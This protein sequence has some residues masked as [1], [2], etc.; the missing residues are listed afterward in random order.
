MTKKVCR[1]V[2]SRLKSRWREHCHG[3]P[4]ESGCALSIG[5]AATFTSEPVVPYLGAKL[6]EKGFL[7]TIAAA[8]YNQILQVCIDHKSAFTT[9]DPQCICLLWRMEDLVAEELKQWLGGDRDAMDSVHEKLR[10]LARAMATLRTRFSGT[11][12]ITMPPFPCPVETSISDLDMLVTTGAFFRQVIHEW[13]ELLADIEGVRVLDLDGLQ[14]DVGIENSLDWRKWYLYRQ[15]YTESFNCRLAD[16]LA[17]ILCAT[18]RS[19]RKCISVDCD[20]TLWGGIIGEDGLGGVLLGHEFPGSAYADFQRLLLHWKNSGILLAVIS[21]N[22]EDDVRQVFRE[23]DGM[24]LRE[25][26]IA[27]W[28]VNWENKPDNLKDVAEELKIGVDSFVFVDDN[29][30]EIAQ[31]TDALPEVQSVQIPDD[32]ALIVDYLKKQHFF[33]RCDVSDEDR[34]RTEMLAAERKRRPLQQ[35]LSR[36]EFIISLR[37][38]IELFVPSEQQIGRVTQLI[39]KTNQFNLTTIRRTEDEVRALL[40][41]P[42]YRMFAAR[43]RDRFG[44]YGLTGLVIFKLDCSFWNI[45]TFLLSCRVLGRK[46]E[47]AILATVIH[48]AGEQGANAVTGA[49]IQSPKN[50]PVKDLLPSHGFTQEPTGAWRIL[51]SNAPSQPEGIEVVLNR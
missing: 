45:D 32:P 39:N 34:R 18:Q 5:I 15:P 51:T 49:Y 12:V 2:L 28:R 3:A 11:I 33:D 47:T 41:S 22:N 27:A 48:L 25:D 46:V 1:A 44:D 17:R 26:D 7:P 29:P 30:F 42:E 43:I 38:Q 35:T 37:L 6:L 36:D 16:Q 13:Q 24:V 50:A 10:D 9:T 4:V 23:H 40:C 31:M 19:S 21:K 20:N 8:P 14:R